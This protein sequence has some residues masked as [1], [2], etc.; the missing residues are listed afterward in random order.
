MWD[1]INFKRLQEYGV[2]DLEEEGG[3]GARNGYW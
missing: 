3:K 2:D 1:T